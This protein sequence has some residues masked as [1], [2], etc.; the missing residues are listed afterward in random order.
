MRTLEREPHLIQ[1]LSMYKET[2]E[3]RREPLE[4]RM[5]G[6]DQSSGDSLNGEAS[7]PLFPNHPRAACVSGSAATL[8][9]GIA[10]ENSAVLFCAPESGIPH[11]IGSN[12][13]NGGSP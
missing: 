10:A 9:W 8:E 6:E 7:F 5:S 4:L 2:G 12:P 11:G 3:P 1:K 13:L